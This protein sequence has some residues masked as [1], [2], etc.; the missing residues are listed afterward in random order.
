VEALNGNG[1]NMKRTANTESSERKVE[2]IKHEK[3][4]RKSEIADRSGEKVK[5]KKKKKKKKIVKT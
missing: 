5:L 3:F 1:H 4:K 2:N